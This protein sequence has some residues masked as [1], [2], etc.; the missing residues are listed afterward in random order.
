MQKKEYF[1][2]FALECEYFEWQDSD[3]PDVNGGYL[4]NHPEQTE[5]KRIYPSFRKNVPIGFPDVVG[6]CHCYS[7]PLGVPNE[8]D[9][10]IIIVEE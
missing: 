4:C 6:E 9:D 10:E 3:E 1:Y 5:T 2:D 7:C 8:D